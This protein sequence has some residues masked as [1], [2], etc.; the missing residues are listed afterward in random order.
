MTSSVIM[1]GLSRTILVL[2]VSSLFPG[3]GGSGSPLF[4]L[5]R[6]AEQVMVF[7]VLSLE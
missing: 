4:G 3:F 7:R 6:A 2:F 5:N 1:R